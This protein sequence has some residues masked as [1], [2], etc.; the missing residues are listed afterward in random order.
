MGTLSPAIQNL[1]A[2]LLLT[3]AAVPQGQPLASSLLGLRVGR[4]MAGGHIDAV[5]ELLSLAGAPIED[6]ALSRAEVDAMLLSGDNAGACARV[7]GLVRTDPQTYWT[8]AL[9]FCRALDNDGGAVSLAVALLR[10][11][12]LVGDDAFFALIGA[13][14]DEAVE[15]LGTLID[16]EPLHL[17]MMRA[18]GQAIP[19]DAVAGASPAILRA[20]AT[21]PNDSIDVRLDA[22]VRAEAAGALSAEVLAEI[23]AAVPYSADDIDAALQRAESGGGAAVDALLYQAATVWQD[24]G[25]R[26]AAVQRTL[27]RARDGGMGF[28][29]PARV[30]L[31]ILR[32]IEPT[33]DLLW[34]AQD[35]ARAL[36]A[37]GDVA[38]AW[39]WLDLCVAE[40]PGNDESAQTAARLWPLLQLADAQAA[41]SRDPDRARSWWLSLPAPKTAG[42]FASRA[43]LYT[44]FDA[45]GDSPPQAAWDP[46]LEAPLTVASYRP[47]AA[48]LHALRDAAAN[49][50]RGE[51]VLLALVSLG[52]PGI[53]GAD[54]AVLHEALLSLRRVGLDAE[55]RAIALEA[56]V[57]RGL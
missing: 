2:R 35:A 26:A 54:T 39:R 56:A 27:Q 33:A 28:G 50:R 42:E 13:L 32:E 55:A 1:A 49:G 25:L 14:T 37:S 38:G 53:G 30:N 17:A 23:Y 57:A 9:A 24:P 36:L 52:E 18:A 46:L 34:F 15:P 51:T 7:L 5:N 22:A 43:L 19:S 41:A 44:L 8:K 45:L 29:T 48:V 31:P 40:A 21:A 6:P 3:T 12:A 47:S 16:P 4:L 10:D 11:Q 20:I